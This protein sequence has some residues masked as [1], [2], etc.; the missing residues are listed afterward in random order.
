MIT[1]DCVSS[2]RG[3][4]E[5]AREAY[6]RF[7]G[8]LDNY[9]MLSKSDK[10]L[11]ERFLEDRNGFALL[12]SSDLTARRDTKISRFKQEQELKLKLEVRGQRHEIR[13]LHFLS[14]LR[15]F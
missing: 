14:H 8:L 2:R 6:E 9:G 1:K 11:H 7:L 13:F 10:R 12:S 3:V 5:R 15:P 4:L